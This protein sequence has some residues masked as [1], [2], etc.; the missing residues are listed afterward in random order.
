VTAERRLVE[1]L[2]RM[3][4]F[5][6]R[7]LL[8]GWVLV[9]SVLVARAAQIQVIQ[10]PI[11]RERA[12]NQQRK[13]EEIAAPRGVVL[14]R[15]GME[16]AV[17]RELYQVSLAP[18]EIRDLEGVTAALTE[19]LGLDEATVRTAVTVE[20]A[21][22]TLPGRYSPY[23]RETLRGLDGVYLTRTLDR[24]YPHDDLALGV[25]GRVREG[26]GRGGIEQRFDELLRGRPGRKVLARDNQGNPLPGQAVLISEPE[27]GGAVVLTLDLDLQEIS[28]GVLRRAIEETKALGGDLLITDPHSGDILA[29]AS[30]R[31]GQTPG[32]SAINTPYEPGSALKPI[33]VAGLLELGLVSLDDSVDVGEGRW[34]VAGRTIADVGSKRGVISVAR[35]LQISSNVGIAK[36]A[37]VMDPADQYQILRDFGFGTATGLGLAGEVGGTLRHPDEWS[38]QSSVSLAI[39]YEIA[40]T[41]LQMAMAYG[42]LANGGKLMEPRLVREIRDSGGRVTERYGPRVIRQV[43]SP[44]VTRQIADVLVDVVEDGTG[45]RARLA[46]FAVAGK[47]GTTRAWSDGGYQKGDY[48]ASFVGFFPAEDP[49]LVVLVMLDRPHADS[50]YGGALAAPVTKATME[51]ILAARQTPLDW[52]A[53][54]R[55]ARVGDH[56]LGSPGTGEGTAPSPGVRFA[57]LSSGALARAPLS[58]TG[59]P[60]VA[61]VA[62]GASLETY[63]LT[64]PDVSGL[65]TRTAARR[66]H[67]LG[68]RVV[69]EGPGRVGTT[70]PRAGALLSPGDTV[71][72]RPSGRGDG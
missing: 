67:N 72:L 3:V 65:P 56:P 64:L 12:E 32:L 63:F 40:V 1:R 49:Q 37:Q 11:W 10:E 8:G 66:L 33:T 53:L 19:A 50:Y 16:L 45:T 35:A 54:A 71:H 21:W 4:D 43:V 41:P 58:D 7:L 13:T 31:E 55:A 22:R 48:F 39:G 62:D 61:S 46:T 70:F 14:D 6:R 27:T 5:R 68:L 17:S 47:S 28:E 2:Q 15:D 23:V 69:W 20:R 24:F 59:L 38:L 51:A 9:T 42:A 52:G 29:M 57:A 30:I 25:L 36:A 26:E 60:E 18:R 34:T 44:D